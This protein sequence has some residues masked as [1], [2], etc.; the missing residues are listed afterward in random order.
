MDEDGYDTE[1]EQTMAWA[2]REM[3]TLRRELDTARARV[4]ELEGR[5]GDLLDAMEPL[6]GSPWDDGPTRDAVDALASALVA[7]PTPK[8]ADR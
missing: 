1:N 3:G 7:T 6:T 5:A 4:A 2:Y 8:D